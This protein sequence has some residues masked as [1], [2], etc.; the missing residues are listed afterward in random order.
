MRCIRRCWSPART[1]RNSTPGQFNLP[2]VILV[3]LC[4]LL[5]IKG[6]TESAAVN[7]TMVL[8]KLAILLFF[9]AIA[10]SG[11]DAKNLHPF[12]NP[13]N[14]K[15]LG[16]MAGVARRGGH[17]VLLVH[18]PRHGGHRRRRSAQPAPQRARSRSCRRW[19][20]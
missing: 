2:P 15:G 3:V 20:S 4:V 8:I 19:A 9:A 1:A 18:R 6:T 11:F 12:F 13:D 10:F 7:T 17:R 16:G 14:S 5:L